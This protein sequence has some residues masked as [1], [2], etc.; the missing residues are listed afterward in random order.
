M[1][2]VFSVYCVVYN[3]QCIVYLV[4]IVLCVLYNVLY[5]VLLKNEVL[6]LQ[7]L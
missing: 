5:D 6:L 2:C 7:L 3:V 1:Y 4:Y